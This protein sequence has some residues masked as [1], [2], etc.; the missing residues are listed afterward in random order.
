M[1]SASRDEMP[2]RE[3]TPDYKPRMADWGGITVAFETAPKGMDPGPMLEG[4]PNGQCQANHWGYLFKGHI[5]VV[6]GDGTTE[7]ITG[8]QA[9]HVRPGHSLTFLEDS[10][11]LEF[12]KTDELEQTFEAV[13]RN[14]GTSHGD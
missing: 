14:A 5:N 13:R 8:G 7:Q 2:E 10:D 9:Y 12:T 6:Y 4:L 3:V 1:P 11:A